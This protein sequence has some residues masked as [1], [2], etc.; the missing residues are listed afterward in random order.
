VQR[1]VDEEE[2]SF[3]WDGNC[4][5]TTGTIAALTVAA[6]V[7]VERKEEN[8][9]NLQAGSRMGGYLRCPKG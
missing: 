3:R 6:T 5:T 7:L 1:G 4:Y 8:Q 2:K 9:G